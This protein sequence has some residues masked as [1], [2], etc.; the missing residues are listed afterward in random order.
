M[1]VQGTSSPTLAR[2]RGDLITLK[3]GEGRMCKKVFPHRE[4][5]PAPRVSDTC[6][7]ESVTM[8][9]T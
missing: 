2:D 3:C 5:S 9:S 1:C 4:D 8:H 6:A 7:L